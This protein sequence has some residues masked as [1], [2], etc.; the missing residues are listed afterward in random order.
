VVCTGSRLGWSLPL[1]HSSVWTP[2]ESL[3]RIFNAP[4]ESIGHETGHDLAARGAARQLIYEVARTVLA[5]IC[6]TIVDRQFQFF[7]GLYQWSDLLE[8]GGVQ[9]LYLVTWYG[10]WYFV[11]LGFF[12]VQFIFTSWAHSL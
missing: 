11:L 12:D 5:T 4:A 7:Q 10:R 9:V 2:G 3:A 1:A 8:V 6:F